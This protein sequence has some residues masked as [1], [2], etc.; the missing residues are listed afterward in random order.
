MGNN[1]AIPYSSFINGGVRDGMELVLQGTAKPNADRFDVN[2]CSAS[3]VEGGDVAFH[4]NPRFNQE[5][6]TVVR[7]HKHCSSWGAEE[8]A[9]RFPFMKGQYFTL[10]VQVRNQG[11]KVLVNNRHFC[12]FHCR[13][14]LTTVQ[15]LVITG[16]LIAHSIHM[17]EER[18]A[19]NA[20]PWS[21][22]IPGGVCDGLDVVVMGTPKP[23][24]DRFSL[25]LCVG[26]NA[27]HGDVVF[28]FNPRFSQGCVVR[29]HK[30]N[31]SWGTVEEKAG[32]MPFVRG[33]PFT[34][35]LMVMN[36]QYQYPGFSAA[37]SMNYPHSSGV[38]QP[39][40]NPSVPAVIPIQGG[41]HPGKIIHITGVPHIGGSRYVL[42]IFFSQFS[43]RVLEIVEILGY[44]PAKEGEAYSEEKSRTAD[45]P[46]VNPTYL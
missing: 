29:N 45:G 24:C 26:Q 36:H 17:K 15:Y 9:G 25:N 32:G 13:L 34:I 7:N 43:C 41:F 2:F 1:V 6:G 11:F 38:P 12:D 39:V 4:F 3:S 42:L 21:T 18:H 28:H 23:H 22:F 30:Q 16:D 14:S 20:H 27:D 46:T 31:G 37:E 19:Q 40:Y 10:Q 33:Q 5:R 35:N 44:R 8:K